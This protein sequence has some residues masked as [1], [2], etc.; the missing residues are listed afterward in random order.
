[1]KIYFKIFQLHF[2]HKKSII[3]NNHSEV[4]QKR[5][6]KQPLSLRSRSTQITFPKNLLENVFES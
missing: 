6:T 4:S 5:L 3:L 2:F 1:M